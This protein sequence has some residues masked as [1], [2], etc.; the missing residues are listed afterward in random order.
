MN[1]RTTGASHR[2]KPP[3]A[4]ERLDEALGV[5]NPLDDPETLRRIRL[6]LFGSAPDSAPIGEGENSESHEKKSNSA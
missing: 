1:L 6:R 3:T 5:Y 4:L 2:K